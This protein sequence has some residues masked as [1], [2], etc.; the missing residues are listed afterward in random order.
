MSV[1]C[2]GGGGRGEVMCAHLLHSAP[3][4]PAARRSNGGPGSPPLSPSALPPPSSP[5][6]RTR[7][8]A[9]DPLLHLHLTPPP[10]STSPLCYYLEK[11]ESRGVSVSGGW[12][13]ASHL[14]LQ[15][16]DEG[17][18]GTPKR[19]PCHLLSAAAACEIVSLMAC[20]GLARVLPRSCCSAGGVNPAPSL[21]PRRLLEGARRLLI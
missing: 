17:V 19:K 6:S 16:G 21:D 4:T 7:K 18:T 3:P 20:R 12:C 2:G 13:R 11:M 15:Y 8:E 14:H 10:P 1:T 5:S 9:S